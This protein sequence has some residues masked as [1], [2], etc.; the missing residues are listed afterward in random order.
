M[1]LLLTLAIVFIVLAIN[2]LWWRFKKPTDEISRKAVHIIVGCFV[3]FWPYYLSW[4]DI[5]LIGLAFLI[6]SYISKHFKILKS[7]HAVSRTTYGELFFAMAV[8]IVAFISHDK[9]IYMTSMLSMGLADGLAAIFGT[10][11]GKS[12][13]YK[14]FG[15]TKSIVGNLVFLII[16]VGL[17]ANF[18]QRSISPHEA[19]SYLILALIATVLEDFS[20]GGIDNLSVP[21]LIAIWLR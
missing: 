8:I 21:L 7:I 6:V 12:T 10:Y 3:A 11:L 17:L 13:R 2:E 5:E 16:V 19:L 20:I 18:R 1:K 4:L 14:I 15:N 9:L